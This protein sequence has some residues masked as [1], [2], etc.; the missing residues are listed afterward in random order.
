MAHT[1]EKRF[2]ISV[3]AKYVSAFPIDL[4]VEG[5]AADLRQ[6]F[7]IVGPTL[8]DNGREYTVEA[9]EPARSVRELVEKVLRA[10]GRNGFDVS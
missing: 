5:A 2:R 7:D 10:L 9:P 3:V 8:E 1:Y 6:T 4:S